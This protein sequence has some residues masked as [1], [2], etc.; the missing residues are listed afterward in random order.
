MKK[1]AL[2]YL[3]LLAAFALAV[4]LRITDITADLPAYFSGGGQDFTTDS[5]YLT[6]YAKTAVQFG[7]WDLFGF[8]PWSAFKISM[9][10]GVSYLLFLV[11]GVSRATAAYAGTVLQ[12][13]S[14]ALI[15]IGLARYL[16]PRSLVMV[17]V[18]FATN[19]L[20]V[21]YGRVPFSENGMLFVAALTFLV[22]AYWFDRLWGK[23][24]VGV[25]IALT[26]LLGKSFGFLLAGG[27][28]LYLLMTERKKAIMPAIWVIAP[29]IA[30][31]LIFTSIFHGESG[32]F[33]FIYEYGVGEHGTPHGFSSPLGF[34]ESLISISSTGLHEYTPALSILFWIA[35]LI[36][37]CTTRKPDPSSKIMLF[38]VGWVI[39]WL[40][41]L[42]PFNYHP[43]RYLFVVMIPI[44]VILALAIERLQDGGLAL[45][46]KWPVWRMVLLLLVNWYAAFT[47]GKGIFYDTRVPEVMHPLVWKALIAGLLVS[48]VVFLLAR[49]S[50]WKPI[51]ANSVLVLVAVGGIV[52][53]TDLWQFGQWFRIRTHMIDDAARDTAALLGPGAVV[54]GQYG[55]AVTSD[56]KFGSLRLFLR[57]DIQTF[58]EQLRQYPVTH[59]AVGNNSL[60]DQ[61]GNSELLKRAPVL[62]TFWLRDNFVKLLRVN[63]LSGNAEAERYRPSEFE[64]AIDLMYARRFEEAEQML[65]RFIRQHP[66]NKAAL[67][68]QYYLVQFVRGPAAAKD[69]LDALYANFH[70]DYAIGLTAAIYYK[71]M[72]EQTGSA[73]AR[74]KSQRYLEES[75]RLSGSQAEN[76]RRM[77]STYL[78]S[79]RVVK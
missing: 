23:I 39:S 63:H 32:L 20:L 75:V 67:L 45:V 21:L 41:A 25:L 28:I 48:A 56:S 46:K 69:A 15:I 40:V 30:T 38:M 27:P 10:S 77:F 37:I 73:E 5:S 18:L 52:M 47:L 17:A 31:T 51:I 49:V 4:G 2:F 57:D 7:S 14:L 64:V 11:L 8:E 78:P 66:K 58:R 1:R 55:P 42:S 59:I 3:A 16:K 12:L 53:A 13:C 36:L 74:A 65:G 54:G 50:K 44:T 71:Q 24:A 61:I 35:A 29:I 62:T 79:D 70:S 9:I 43:V 34:F 19:Y 68:E 76:T 33:G 6:L 72:A 26:A 60:A 22:Y